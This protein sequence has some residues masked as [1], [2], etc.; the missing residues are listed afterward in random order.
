MLLGLW[1]LILFLLLFT[2]ILRV[3][4][5]SL[6]VL[7]FLIQLG[8]QHALSDQELAFAHKEDFII[9]FT[10]SEDDTALD[11]LHREKLGTKCL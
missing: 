3:Q 8:N 2:D 7:H 11:A 6:G 10:L 1:W 5:Q 4:E 9:G